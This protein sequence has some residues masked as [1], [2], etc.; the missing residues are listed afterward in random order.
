MTK[1]LSM[2]DCLVERMTRRPK[3]YS[4]TFSFVHGS[5]RITQ[6]IYC[7]RHIDSITAFVKGATRHDSFTCHTANCGECW[8]ESRIEG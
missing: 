3:E 8:R 7:G 5:E 4:G 6:V 1:T 2:M